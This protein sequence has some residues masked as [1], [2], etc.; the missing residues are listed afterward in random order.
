MTLYETPDRRLMRLRSALDSTAQ[1]MGDTVSKA[2]DLED[3]RRAMEDSLR[4]FRQ[5]ER[6]SMAQ[7]RQIDFRP[8][9]S[10]VP[11]TGTPTA[12]PTPTPRSRPGPPAPSTTTL[13][14]TVTPEGQLRLS[15]GLDLRPQDI[16]APGTSQDV[17]GQITPLQQG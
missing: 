9:P 14:E 6:D 12:T 10:Y 5:V 7:R 8:T 15:Q 4:Q 2:V 16:T 11:P 17:V 3:R 13:G 1:S